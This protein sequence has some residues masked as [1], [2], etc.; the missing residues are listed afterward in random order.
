MENAFGQPQ[1]VVVLG[2]TSDIAEALVDELVRQETSADLTVAY[3]TL[4]REDLLQRLGDQMLSALAAGG[5]TGP[6]VAGGSD[7]LS[8][9]QLEALQQAEIGRAHV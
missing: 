5:T 9:R 8:A 3:V 7:H 2:G 6:H 4:M 1:S